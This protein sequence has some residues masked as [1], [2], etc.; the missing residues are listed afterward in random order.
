MAQTPLD[1]EAVH[2]GHENV[3]HGDAG[4]MIDRLPAI[5]T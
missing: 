5:S 2:G 1:F 4:L 3:E